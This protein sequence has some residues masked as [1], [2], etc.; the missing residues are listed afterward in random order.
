[1]VK[2]QE[3]GVA[4]GCLECEKFPH[5]NIMWHIYEVKIV[6]SCWSVFH[7]QSIQI[8]AAEAGGSRAVE[9]VWQ[10]GHTVLSVLRRRATSE[11]TLRLLL[12]RDHC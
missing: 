1:M 7:R 11:N 2:Q 12:W 10:P 4:T 8:T 6:T 9:C 5:T 3:V